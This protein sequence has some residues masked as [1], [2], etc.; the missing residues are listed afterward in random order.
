MTA[1][2]K[3]TSADLIVRTADG[4]VL[5]YRFNGDGHHLN[6]NL[7][8]AVDRDQIRAVD[9]LRADP[10][11]SEQTKIVATLTASTGWGPEPLLVAEV[12]EPLG[13]GA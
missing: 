7:E 11:R 12:V 9:S 5:R 6:V 10:Y 1:R 8:Q 13:G 4:Q 3:V 2:P